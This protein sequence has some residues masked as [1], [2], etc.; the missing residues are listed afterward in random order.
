MRGLLLD[1]LYVTTPEAVA[2]CKAAEKKGEPPDSEISC[3]PPVQR[4]ETVYHWQLLPRGMTG[5]CPIFRVCFG[6]VVRL[7]S[8]I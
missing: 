3:A 7:M 2:A 6:I 8:P 1:G 4:D 5:L